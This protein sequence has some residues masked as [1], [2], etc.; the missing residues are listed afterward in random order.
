MTNEVDILTIKVAGKGDDYITADSFLEVI[1]ETVAILRELDPQD[2]LVWKLKNASINSPLSMTFVAMP[3]AGAEDFPNGVSRNYLNMFR[4]LDRGGEVSAGTP[5]KAVFRAKR[6][7]NV[8]NNGVAQ[9][10]FSSPG[11]EPVTPT[12]RVQATVDEYEASHRDVYRDFATLEGELRTVSVDGGSK[13]IIR[14]R[15]TGHRTQC[16]IPHEKLED[17][18]N[19]LERRVAVTGSVRYK[20]GRPMHIDVESFEAMPDRGSLPQFDDIKGIDVTGGEDSVAF[21]RKGR[22]AD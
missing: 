9:I 15:I 6:L 13:F 1:R 10:T 3:R 19:A 4:G 11:A 21:V 22:D 14:D 7:M 16:T 12:Q 20:A 2:G 8:L 17:A 5:P 18:K